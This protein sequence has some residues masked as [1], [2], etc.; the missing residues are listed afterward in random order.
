MKYSSSPGFVTAEDFSTYLRD[1]FDV[2]YAESDRFPKMMNVGLHCR[3]IGHPGRAKALEQF[4][5]HIEG[6]DGVWVCRREEIARHW[7]AV[8][9]HQQPGTIALP[10]SRSA[11]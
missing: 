4:L 10:Q 1:S 11:L 9:P 2:L 5:D 8:H 3:M 6:F 7:M